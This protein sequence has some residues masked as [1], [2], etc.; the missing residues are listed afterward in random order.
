MRNWN[1]YKEDLEAGQQY[2]DY[3]LEKLLPHGIQLMYYTSLKKQKVGETINGIE[4]K[5]DR[6]FRKTGNLYITTQARATSNSD[7]HPCGVTKLDNSWLYMIGDEKDVYIL[8]KKQLYT[9]FKMGNFKE[10]EIPQETNKGFLINIKRS[11]WLILNH[12]KF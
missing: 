11:N 5:Y 6:K 12:I 1:D 8:G 4:V 2:Q 7:Y 10:F 9:F 3:L